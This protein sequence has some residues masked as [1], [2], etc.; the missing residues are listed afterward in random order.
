MSIKTICYLSF[1]YPTI[2]KSIEMAGRYIEGGCDAIEVSIPPKDPY[3]DS[4]FLQELYRV[5]LAQTDDYSKYLEGIGRMTEQY[6]STEFFF[7]LYHEVI[8]AIGAENRVLFFRRCSFLPKKVFRAIYA[9]NYCIQAGFCMV[10]PAAHLPADGGFPG[11]R[12]GDCRLSA[13]RDVARH[14]ARL[15]AADGRW[16]FTRLGTRRGRHSKESVSKGP[17]P[18]ALTASL[19][20]SPPNFRFSLYRMFKLCYTRPSKEL[21]N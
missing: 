8:M 13:R 9:V 6:P 15:D 21:S 1:G 4:A 12:P 7:V 10:C 2:E 14:A 19:A 20:F 16:A 17:A 5:A 3:R 11:R 18:S